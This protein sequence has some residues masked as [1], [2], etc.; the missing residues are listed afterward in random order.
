MLNTVVP[1]LTS[2][3]MHVRTYE[4]IGLAQYLREPLIESHLVVRLTMC[5]LVGKSHRCCVVEMQLAVCCTELW[6]EGRKCMHDRQ[7][8]IGI[9]LGAVVMAITLLLG[10]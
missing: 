9:L 10:V 4:M 6:T 2:C 1:D 8:G 3:R 7:L 5:F